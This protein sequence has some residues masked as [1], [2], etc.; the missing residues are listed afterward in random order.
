MIVCAGWRLGAPPHPSATI[1]WPRVTC[2]CFFLLHLLRNAIEYP[3]EVLSVSQSVHPLVHLSVGSSVRWSITPEKNCISQ[4]FLATIS[5]CDESNDWYTC[6]ESLLWLLYERF[7]QS[8]CLFMHPVW[9]SL[10]AVTQ[11]GRLIFSF[12]AFYY[13]VSRDRNMIFKH[14]MLS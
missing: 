3:L 5:S 4:L 13:F 14:S 8:V 9:D 7:K 2:S 1:L 10:H 11:S 6:F 12:F